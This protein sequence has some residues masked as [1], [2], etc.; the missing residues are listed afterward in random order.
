[1]EN[2]QAVT[3]CSPCRPKHLLHFSQQAHGAVPDSVT[4]VPR[5]GP[6]DCG[7]LKTSAFIHVRSKLK[8]R[9]KTRACQS[10]CVVLHPSSSNRA[11]QITGQALRTGVNGVCL[12]ST[13]CV[14]PLRGNQRTSPIVCSCAPYHTDLTSSSR[15]LNSVFIPL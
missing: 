14:C 13:S 9:C 1:M 2:G 4:L 7:R 10:Q 5:A 11:L 8:A 3:A 12:H 15:S 6:V